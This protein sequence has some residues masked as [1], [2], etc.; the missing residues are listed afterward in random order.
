M[1]GPITD[2]AWTAMRPYLSHDE[3]ETSPVWDV[4]TSPLS[5][6]PVVFH[7]A[8]TAQKLIVARVSDYAIL[9]TTDSTQAQSCVPFIKVEWRPATPTAGGP[10]SSSHWMP[11]WCFHP[12]ALDSLSLSVLPIAGNHS[13]VVMWLVDAAAHVCSRCGSN[14]A[15]CHDCP[16]HALPP[17]SG[18]VRVADVRSSAT[19]FS[20][21]NENYT[22]IKGLTFLQPS[23]PRWKSNQPGGFLLPAFRTAKLSRTTAEATYVGAA[24][25]SGRKM[26]FGNA[27][28]Q[29]FLRSI[30]D[31]LKVRDLSEAEALDALCFD[32][33][34]RAL[35]PNA[36]V[37]V[38]SGARGGALTGQRPRKR[39]RAAST[40]TDE[41]EDEEGGDSSDDD[42][43]GD[44]DVSDDDFTSAGVGTGGG[45]NSNATTL[46][47]G[48]SE[49]W[50][51]GG[52]GR[53]ASGKRSARGGG[54]AAFASRAK[55]AHQLLPATVRDAGAAGPPAFLAAEAEQRTAML[56]TERDAAV[57]RA[58][59]SAA[60][61][62][63][64]DKR[65]AES[66]SRAAASELCITQLQDSLIDALGR[67]RRAEAALASVQHQQ[68][69][70]QHQQLQQQYAQQQARQ[71]Q[72]PQ[73]FIQQ[74]A[75]QQHVQVPQQLAQ[76]QQQ[77]QLH[78]NQLAQQ[79]QA[80]RQLP[81]IWPGNIPPTYLLPP[82]PPSILP[83]QQQHF[84]PAF[85]PP[86]PPPPL[87]WLQQLPPATPSVMQQT[88]QF[89]P[90]VSAPLPAPIQLPHL[91]GYDIK[92]Y[93]IIN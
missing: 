45:N 21:M 24:V 83:H 42:D 47:A 16:L 35:A 37:R 11:L 77:L 60:E 71:Q 33:A 52:S 48:T 87:N 20:K 19:T 46:R 76:P 3:H 7:R 12:L 39:A 88:T 92:F 64:A 69:Q 36:T 65:A 93:C 58:V 84:A 67:A 14:D 6:S 80:Q 78:V 9:R 74:Q 86:P 59:A 51:R 73:H 27:T 4:R 13:A 75:P 79:Q 91:S 55:E 23:S 8:M 66:A 2:A 53:R 90:T 81:S 49:A 57:Q 40:S 62:A 82:P 32:A 26:S 17:Q 18:G 41:E 38:F 68:L 85:L 1:S 56:L 10:S 63:T 44:G 29:C 15:A 28:A 30:F 43:G 54:A 31:T 89:P 5:L 70:H 72:A 50:V 61:A 34:E 22:V 25:Y